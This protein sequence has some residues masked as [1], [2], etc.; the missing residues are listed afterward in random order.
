MVGSN[1][2]LEKHKKR[3]GK[4]PTHDVVDTVMLQKAVE[5]FDM[6]ANFAVSAGIGI[7]VFC[8]GVTELAL[9]AYQAMVEPSGGYVLPLFSLDAPQLQ[10]SLKFILENTYMSRSR[11]IPE[12]MDDN[13]G[14]ECILDIRTDSFVTPTQLCGSGNVLPDLSCDMFEKIGRAHV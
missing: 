8:C 2:V 11:Y 6:T 10:Q 12:E 1:G 14:A 9:P 4:R 7:D 13:D 5:Y 3:R